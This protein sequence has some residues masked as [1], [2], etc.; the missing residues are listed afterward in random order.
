MI[1][2]GVVIKNLS[3]GIGN[4]EIVRN[5]SAEIPKGSVAGIAGKTGS[6]KSTI[7]KTIAGLIPLLYNRFKVE[8]EIIIFG[9]SPKEALTKGYISYVPQDPFSFF[10]G[11]NLREESV[12]LPLD[13]NERNGKSF[14]EMSDGELYS[15]L[16]A[17]SKKIGA[18]VLLIDEPSSHLDSNRAESVYREIYKKAK[19]DDMVVF[20]S[21]HR[22]ELLQK[23]CDF[24]FKIGDV[25]YPCVLGRYE[26]QAIADKEIVHLDKVS[27]S[28]GKR[29]V[30]KD[31]T[32][33][34]SKGETVVIYGKNGEG[35]TTLLN[36]VAGL[37]KVS[38]GNRKVDKGTKIFYIPQNPIFWFENAKVISF[39]SKFVREKSEVMDALATFNLEE[40]ADNY[41]YSLSVGQARL[42][43]IASAF[44]SK[45]D[46]VIIDEPW[47]GL[48]CA[49]KR[50]VLR[51]IKILN[52]VGRSAL[53]ATHSREMAGL[54]NKVFLL[55]QGYLRNLGECDD[56]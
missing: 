24:V 46:L 3:I 39:I 51:A 17:L 18:K 43:S 15:A 52:D 21:D 9:A 22:V 2:E 55:K 40:L 14:Y 33:S 5:F 41:T 26:E 36:I 54:F 16:F 12:F 30:L 11:R 29:E 53:V 35:K 20:V 42:V 44:A 1:E 38:K 45:A 27:Y 48:D 23:Y 56:E 34:I 13:F 49:S 37:L 31:I 25:E 19:E 50:A 10:I 8:G 47:L 32:L 4:K 6:G 7:L 28:Y